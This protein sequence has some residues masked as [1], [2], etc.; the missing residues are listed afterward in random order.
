MTR[1][2]AFLSDDLR[3]EIVDHC[4]SELPNEGCGLLA[5][6]DGAVV[7]VY[8]TSNSDSSPTSFTIPPEEHFEALR[9]AESNGWEIGG[10]FHSHPAGPAIMSATD[11]ARALEADW[12]YF[13]VGLRDGTPIVAAHT[14]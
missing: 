2:A 3:R 13:V 9:D 1:P 10:V 6:S 14:I 11:L 7:R 12:T 4:L 8:P 5:V